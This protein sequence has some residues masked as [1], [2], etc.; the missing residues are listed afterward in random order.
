MVRSLRFNRRVQPPRLHRGGSGEPVLLLHGFTLSHHSWRGVL[1]DLAR[2]HDVLALTM[3]GH[4]GGD[5]LAMRGFSIETLVDGVERA[6]DETG[7]DTCHVV[8]NSLGGWVALELARRGRVRSVVAVAPAGGWVPWRL[9]H[10]AVGVKFAALLP[11]AAIAPLVVRAPGGRRLADRV[12]SY[13]LSHDAAAV[14]PDDLRAALVASTQCRAFLPFM[15]SALRTGA[16][17]TAYDEV[18]APVHLVLCE[19][20]TVIPP[21]VY[22]RLFAE[23]LPDVEVTTLPGVGHVPMLEAPRIVADVIRR[24]VGRHAWGRD[25]S[26]A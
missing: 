13:A 10:L 15:V 16:A 17:F 3:P 22:G 6:L 25:A 7:W 21:R 19:K 5:P 24:H 8:G 14:H 23:R 9:P 1:D 4:W 26:T 11:L 20:D 18:D 12:A 2:D